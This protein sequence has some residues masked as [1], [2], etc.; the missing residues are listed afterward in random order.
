MHDVA[1]GPRCKINF[2]FSNMGRQ[3]QGFRSVYSS[4]RWSGTSSLCNTLQHTATHCNTLPRN[5]TYCHTLPHTAA[6]CSTYQHIYS[7]LQLLVLCVVHPDGVV[8]GLVATHCN[9][10]QHTAAHIQLQHLD[11]R[12]FYSN[13]V[14]RHRVATQCNVAHCSTPKHT[15]THCNTLLYTYSVTQ[16]L[17]L[18]KTIP[19][20]VICCIFGTQCNTVQHIATT[21]CGALPKI[22]EQTRCVAVF[23]FV[24]CLSR[25]SGMSSW[26]NTLQHTAMHRKSPQLTE[27]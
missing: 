4:S 22:A 8:C 19:I 20:E 26:C 6:H 14:V 3:A 15:A 10:L 2:Y 24:Y 7:V 25:W 27:Q 1:G 16:H 13:C 11:L 23:R 9:I 17:D 21:H 5:A 12:I 18:Y